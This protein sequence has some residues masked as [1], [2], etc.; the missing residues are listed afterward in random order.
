MNS[1]NSKK[2]SKIQLLYLLTY[3]SFFLFS[4]LVVNF[5]CVCFF[6]LFVLCLKEL[7]WSLVMVLRMLWYCAQIIFLNQ[8]LG[9]LFIYLIYDLS[10]SLGC[11]R[12]GMKI[13]FVSQESIS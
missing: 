1:R 4:F 10:V 13:P 6:I 12:L 9:C 11:G 8:N 7:G 3:F 5:M 2:I